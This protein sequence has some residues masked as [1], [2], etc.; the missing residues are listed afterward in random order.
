MKN[1]D[2]KRKKFIRIKKKI[3]IKKLIKNYD[4]RKSN[5][6]KEKYVYKEKCKKKKEVIILIIKKKK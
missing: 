5:K 3:Q 4:E 2:K 6:S 1:L